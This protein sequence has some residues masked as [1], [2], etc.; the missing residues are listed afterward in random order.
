MERNSNT[1]AAASPISLPSYF[2]MR[3]IDHYGKAR[4]RRDSIGGFG[5]KGEVLFVRMTND[6]T[7]MRPSGLAI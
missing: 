5:A 7:P 6:A 1:S 3:R 4:K 2:A